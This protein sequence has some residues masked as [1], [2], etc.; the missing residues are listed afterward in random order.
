MLWAPSLTKRRLYAGWGCT[1]RRL[2]WGWSIRLQDAGP[3]AVGGG[4]QLP[5]GIGGRL[6]FLT[7]GT[8]HVATLMSNRQGSRPPPREVSREGEWWGRGMPFTVHSQRSHCRSL[9]TLGSLSSALEGR[10]VKLLLLK[11][12][13][14][15]CLWTDL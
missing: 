9:H 15:K 6:Y 7:T 4:P 5:A 13:V 3:P 12:S 8:F 2:D 10:A 11:G 14:S 1:I